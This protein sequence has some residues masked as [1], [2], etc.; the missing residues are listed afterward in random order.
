M[1]KVQKGQMSEAEMK[2]QMNSA[3]CRDTNAGAFHV[4]L[5]NQIA[6]KNEGFVADV[7]R[8]SEV[9]NQPIYAYETKI[10]AEK[11]CATPGAAAGTV[12]EVTVET[13]MYYISEVDQHWSYVEKHD[14][15]GTKEYQYRLEL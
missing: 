7:T 10:I 8:D 5:T 6:V 2:R 15:I 14:S 12:R 9:W 3:E 13:T 4:A 1:E 11:N